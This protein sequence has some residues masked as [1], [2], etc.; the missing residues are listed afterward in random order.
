M[1]VERNICRWYNATSAIK[2]ACD[3]GLIERKWIEEYCWKGGEGCVR[4]CRLEEQRCVSPDY[5]LPD[6]TVAAHL[7]NRNF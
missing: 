3:A 6:G 4:K 2:R 1:P 5:L 7:R